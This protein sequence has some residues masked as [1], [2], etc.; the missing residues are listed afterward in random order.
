MRDITSS[1]RSVAAVTVAVRVIAPISASS[2]TT[3]PRDRVADER[4]VVLH[5]R[6][7]A[8]DDEALGADGVLTGQDPSGR[9]PHLGEQRSD[10]P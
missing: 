1:C 3:D 10:Q 8:Q 5:H 7:A 6:V 9:Q 2:P 4:A